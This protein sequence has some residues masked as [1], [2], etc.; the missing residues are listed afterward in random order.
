MR[1]KQLRLL[2][3]AGLAVGL[4]FA[5]A[6]AATP[7][8]PQTDE[9][10]AL[11]KRWME[12]LKEY[13]AFGAEDAENPV[14]LAFY[15]AAATDENLA[16][17]RDTYDL[18]AVAGEGAELDR[19]IN[20][21]RWVFEL[22]H[23]ADA[24]AIPA[25]RNAFTMIHMARAEGKPI[26]CY[27]KTV[28]LNEVYLAMGFPSRHTHLLPYDGESSE[29][30]FVTSV[31]SRTLGRW[32]MMDPDF[33]VY[34]TDADGTILGVGE[35]RRRL[36]TGAP[37]RVVRVG[38]R[39]PDNTVEGVDYLWFLSRFVFKIRCP[40]YSM[41]NQDSRPVRE[42]YELIPDG[43]RSETLDGTIMTKRGKKILFVD[44]E[45]AFWQA[46]AGR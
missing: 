32:I 29:S 44:D 37:L 21:M 6:A 19:V 3:V 23:H 39:D 42:Y 14:A 24:P 4:S 36:I 15:Y 16:K 38:R 25:E 40:I 45:A 22:A 26:N 30:H 20:L 12:L 1:P 28:I 11:G 17:L 31:Y 7:A 18:N 10:A 27:M 2:V 5:T 13:P 33:G 34:V 43:Y 9:D 41:F 46:P 8:P 35:I